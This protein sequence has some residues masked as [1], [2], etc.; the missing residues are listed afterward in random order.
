MERR[1]I[2]AL[3]GIGLR[4]RDITTC[5][6]GWFIVYG[7]TRTYEIIPCGEE[8]CVHISD[9]DKFM[10]RED[11]LAEFIAKCEAH[12]AINGMGGRRP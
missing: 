2:N 3:L 9:Y 6:K 12:V 8:L 5:E 7:R 4:E 10:V 11:D 1:I